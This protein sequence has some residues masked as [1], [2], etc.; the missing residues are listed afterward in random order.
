[1]FPLIDPNTDTD[2]IRQDHVQATNT[3]LCFSTSSVV[4]ENMNHIEL[5]K[6]QKFPKWYHS[7]GSVSLQRAELST[8]VPLTK[9]ETAEAFTL[10]RNKK[11]IYMNQNKMTQKTDRQ[12]QL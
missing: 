9:N 8:S 6:K 7:G 12:N 4:I 11:H 3:C 1:M 5:M 2:E 10:Q